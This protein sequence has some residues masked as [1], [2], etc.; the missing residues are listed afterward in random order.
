[1]V[2]IVILASGS[3]EPH[4]TGGGDAW[5]KVDGAKQKLKGIAL[6]DFIKQ[7]LAETADLDNSRPDLD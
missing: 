4:D 6:T 3:T 7:R 5:V 1:V 2:E